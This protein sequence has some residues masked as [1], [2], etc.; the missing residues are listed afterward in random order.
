MYIVVYAWRGGFIVQ[1]IR[2]NKPKIKV[3]STSIADAGI[4][5]QKPEI[6]LHREID[7]DE[8]GQGGQG[9]FDDHDGSDRETLEEG[10]GDVSQ[11]TIEMTETIHIIN[12]CTKPK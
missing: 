6:E 11:N 7:L 4:P 9:H 3:L 2:S 5:T 1:K 8:I 12:R 10:H